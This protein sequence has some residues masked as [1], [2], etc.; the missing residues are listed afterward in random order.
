ME[1]IDEWD[2][3]DPMTQTAKGKRRPRQTRFVF[4]TWGGKRRG[5]GRKPKEPGRPGVPHRARPLLKKPLPLHVTLRMAPHVWNLRSRRSFRALEK[6]LYGGANRFGLR[7]L[8]FSLQGNHIHLLIEADDKAALLR[9]MKGLSVRIAR[10]MNHLM[11]RRGRVIGD[12]Y[13]ARPL[14]TPTEVKRALAYVRDNARKHAA[15]WGDR[16]PPRWIDPYSSESPDLTI[17]LPA[18][19]TWFLR[20]SERQAKQE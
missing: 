7:L 11:K 6:A 1:E 10:G 8:R 4:R 17:A 13:H 20:A 5:A 12:R 2:E 9:G 18:P 3:G 16:L 14:R 19:E 15:A